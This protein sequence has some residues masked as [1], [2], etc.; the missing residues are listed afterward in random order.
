[1][2]KKIKEAK[3]ISSD[4]KKLRERLERFKNGLPPLEYLSV[5]LDTEKLVVL[6]SRFK[7]T[8]E[9]LVSDLHR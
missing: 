3:R 8:R 5:E 9:C 7:S 1:M 2:N 6:E 4:F